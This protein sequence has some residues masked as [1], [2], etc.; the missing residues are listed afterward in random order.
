MGRD[1][2]RRRPVC[3][4]DEDEIGEHDYGRK[5]ENRNGEREV[6]VGLP[7]PLIVQLDNVLF[8]EYLDNQAH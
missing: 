6:G 1:V 4:I 3:N 2:G 7:P 8:S 5:E